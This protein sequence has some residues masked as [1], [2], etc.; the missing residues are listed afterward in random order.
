MFLFT[1][2]GLRVVVWNTQGE[3]HLVLLKL[4]EV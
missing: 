3:D 1:F 2:L 4:K